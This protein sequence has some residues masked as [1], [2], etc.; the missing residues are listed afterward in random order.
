MGNPAMGKIIY[1][2]ASHAMRRQLHTHTRDEASGEDVQ[3]PISDLVSIA[4]FLFYFHHVSQ[5]R[6][7]ENLVYRS[8]SRNVCAARI[9][10]FCFVPGWLGLGERLLGFLRSEIAAS[11]GRPN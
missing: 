10:R 1:G 5:R 3:V 11:R 7:E 8:R 2:C 9:G 4:V 6:R